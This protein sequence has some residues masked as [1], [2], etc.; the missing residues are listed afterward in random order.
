MDAHQFCL[1]Y[2]LVG[3]VQY[4][5]SRLSSG[6]ATREYALWWQD[7]KLCQTDHSGLTCTCISGKYNTIISAS[8]WCRLIKTNCE[9]TRNREEKQRQQEKKQTVHYRRDVMLF[10]V[11]WNK[12]VYISSSTSAISLLRS[13]DTLTC[14]IKRKG[15]WQHTVNSGPAGRLGWWHADCGLENHSQRRGRIASLSCCTPKI[16]HMWFYNHDWPI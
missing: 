1:Y 7:F 3:H 14:R 9:C 5:R 15:R 16:P 8:H 2:L 13:V 4:F 6:V 11:R 10:A 12:Y